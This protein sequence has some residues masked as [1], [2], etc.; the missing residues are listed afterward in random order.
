MD[1]REWVL[2]KHLKGHDR[3]LFCKRMRSGAYGVFRESV[4]WETFAYE[5]GVL[6]YL[7]PADHFIFALTHDWRSDGKPVDW[8]IEPVLEKIKASDSHQRDI[9]AEAIESYERLK[10]KKAKQVS[11]NA[12]AFFSDYRREFARSTNHLNTSTMEK[13]DRR[14]NHDA[15]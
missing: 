8:G 11:S 12:E 2:T 6:S 9:A 15:Y 10:E 13:V 4:R 1:N 3:K 7:R 5:S 14:R